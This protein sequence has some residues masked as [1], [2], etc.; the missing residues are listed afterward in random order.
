MGAFGNPLSAFITK[1]TSAEYTQIGK[2]NHNA[3]ANCL[4]T[5]KGYDTNFIIL[6]E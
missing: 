1:D 2:I 6:L 3:E 4:I 5:D